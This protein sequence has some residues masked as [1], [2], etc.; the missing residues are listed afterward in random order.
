[1]FGMDRQTDRQTDK[2]TDGSVEINAFPVL[3]FILMT[4]HRLSVLD[5]SEVGEG[6]TE[7]FLR[8]PFNPHKFTTPRPTTPSTLDQD[9]PVHP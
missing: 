3:R 7:R 9:Y 2:Q 4:S 1:M 5:E 8:Y 6:K